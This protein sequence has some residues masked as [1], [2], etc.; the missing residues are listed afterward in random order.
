MNIE[1]S[2]EWMTRLRP[3]FEIGK[4]ADKTHPNYRAASIAN[5]HYCLC[6]KTDNTY[7]NHDEFVGVGPNGTIYTVG[8]D[9]RSR[10]ISCGAGKGYHDRRNVPVCEP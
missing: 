3:E 10:K 9:T 7:G 8:M 2:I 1:K 5:F 4:T 6:A